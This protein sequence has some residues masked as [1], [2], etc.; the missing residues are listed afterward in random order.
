MPFAAVS[1]AITEAMPDEIVHVEIAGY[2]DVA[3]AE[4]TSAV[5]ENMLVEAADAAVF[6]IENIDAQVARA[7]PWCTE[8]QRNME[9]TM[10]VRGDRPADFRLGKRAQ[11]N[12]RN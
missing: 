12:S 11:D 3:V 4:T 5:H 7:G 8:R 6:R 1:K 9:N 2:G 10:R